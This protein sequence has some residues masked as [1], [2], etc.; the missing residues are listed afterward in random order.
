MKKLKIA[1]I[2]PVCNSET[3]IG[4]TLTSL[5]RQ[6]LNFDELIV[7]DDASVDKSIVIARE[8]ISKS[9][10]LLEKS[11]AEVKIIEHEKTRGLAA[12]YNDGIKSSSSDLIV[13]L[14]SDIILEEDSLRKLAA[15][16][17]E[18][19]SP[20]IVATYHSVIHPYEI[21]K[22]YNF[23]Q[24]CFF[25]RLV[26]K[27]FYGLDGK[28]DCFRKSALERVGLFDEGRFRNAGE[29]GDIFYKLS[30]LGKIEK[31]DA[32]IV[33]L[34]SMDSHFSYLDI[35]RKQA[36]YSESQGILLR[37]WRIDNLQSLPRIF[38]REILIML[39]FVPYVNIISAIVIVAYSFFYTKLVY[40]EEYNNLRVL[41]LPF[42]NI[43]LLFVSFFYSLRGLIYGRQKT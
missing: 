8:L 28:F 29:D 40:L 20:N 14:H 19:N 36:Q 15:P 25:A 39:L 33:H 31:T 10:R 13:T 37:I 41:V 27:K 32:E 21:W 5:F 35:I 18:E 9:D 16:F 22:K 7:I 6:S 2:I 3:I 12:S 4:K 24:K 30:K 1:I 43:Y 34:H 11:G 23:W 17:F 42:L 26:G 38:F